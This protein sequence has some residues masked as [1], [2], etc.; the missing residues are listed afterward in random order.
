MG[1]AFTLDDDDDDVY[2]IH[3]G[4][5]RRPLPEC[6][7]HDTERDRAENAWRVQ[8]V[9]RL[10]ELMGVSP[11]QASALAGKLPGNENLR[12]AL[13]GLEAGSIWRPD[14]ARFRCVDAEWDRPPA[15]MTVR[16]DGVTVQTIFGRDV[17]PKWCATVDAAKARFPRHVLITF[18]A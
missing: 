2:D 4:D 9:S 6:F 1:H 17:A 11:E 13:G 18:N 10:A 8:G 3:R 5:R 16:S 14:P 15:K 12:L 7:A